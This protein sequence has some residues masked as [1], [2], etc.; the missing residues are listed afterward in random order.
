MVEPSNELEEVLSRASDSA[1]RL[2]H[3]Y[4]TLEHILFAMLANNNFANCLNGF[5]TNVSEFKRLVSEHLQY[6][7]QE[8]TVQHD[9]EK[10]KKTAAFE[11][12]MNKSFT[13][14]IFNNRQ[15]VEITDAFLMIMNEKH[16]WAFYYSSQ[17]GINKEKFADYLLT[18]GFTAEPEE[19]EEQDPRSTKI[20]RAHV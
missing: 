1:K 3:E 17:V 20:G 18:S 5:G 13:Q 6:K 19:S 14:V 4:L 8:I 7:C 12:V 2:H 11:R 9:V 10:P 15:T 16:S